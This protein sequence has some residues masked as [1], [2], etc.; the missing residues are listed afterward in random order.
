MTGIHV[1]GLRETSAALIAAGAEVDDLKDVLGSIAAEAAETM[2]G[3]VPVGSTPQAGR[4]HVRDTIR[5]NRAKG[6]A[7]VTLGGAKAPH[8]HVLRAT[9]PSKFVERTDTHME[10]RAVEMLTDG[11][12]EIAKR[13]GLS[14]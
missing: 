1:E 13:N 12:D 8:A 10:T 4:V 11:W 3:Y 2:R 5:P 6:A 9:H 14:T 7:I